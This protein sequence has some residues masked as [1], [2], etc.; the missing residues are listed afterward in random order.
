MTRRIWAAIAIAVLS[1]A[2]VY[3]AIGQGGASALSL[4]YDDATEVARGE[5]LY[6]AHCASCH[7]A[8]LAGAPDWRSRDADG[9]LPAPPHDATG[10][11]WHHPDAVLFEITKYG[12]EAVVG[13]G[14]QSRMMGFGDILTDAEILATLGYIKS[15]WPRRIVEMH[16]E[17]NAASR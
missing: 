15:T 1:V 13:G 2:G 11:T 10:H 5:A 9:Y 17:M 7:G 4:P 14:Y 3:G 6:E 16:D 8:D 12:T